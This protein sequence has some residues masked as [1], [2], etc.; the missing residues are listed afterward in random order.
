MIGLGALGGLYGARLA[1]AGHRVHFVVRTDPAAI[2]RAG[3]VVRS[4]VGDLEM[5]VGRPDSQE[6]VTVGQGAVGAPRADVV[7][8]ATKATANAVVA[9]LLEDLV[10]PTTTVALLQNGLGGEEQLAAVVPNATLLG[11][12]CFV[13]ADLQGPGRIE[14]LDYGG[15]TLAQFQRSGT[16]AGRTPAVEAVAAD[17]TAAGVTVTTEEDLVLARWKKLVWNIPYNGLSVV[18]G[19]GTDELMADPASR[20]LVFDLM[21]EVRSG[22]ASQGRTIE[23]DFVTRMLAD[24]EA[25]TPYAPSMLRDFERRRPLEVEA[26]YRVPVERARAAGTEMAGTEALLRQLQFLDRRNR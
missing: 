14:H 16:P 7:V 3:L 1:A 23:A 6:Q 25:M 13:C 12:L 24:T 4:P 21:E 22:A 17:L 8:V 18:L 2:R 15:V 19:A 5:T 26:I 9:P 10:E 20:A 11:G